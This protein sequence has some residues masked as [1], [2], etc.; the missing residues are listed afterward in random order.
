[1]I[2]TEVQLA[3][4][5][6]LT[7]VNGPV[8]R[9]RGSERVGMYEVVLVGPEHLV[10]EVIALDHREITIQVY[11]ETS[12][13]RS[14]T[15]VYGTGAPLSVELGPG[16][17]SSVFD[18][19]QRPLTA[20]EMRTGAWIGRGI[21]LT[22]LYRRARWDF[23]PVAVEGTPVSGGS[24][25]GL[26]AETS[27]V[28][29]K[30]MVPPGISGR[31]VWLAGE[32]PMTLDDEV[33]RI[34]DGRQEHRVTMLQH[35]P[36][37][38]PRPYVTRLRPSELLTTGQRVLDTFFPIPKGGTSAIPGGF[39]AGKTMLQHQI[40]KW[41]DASVIVYVGC[42]ERGNEMA[43]VLR[44]FPEL[45]DPR[46]GHPLM[47]RT[48][49][50]VNTSNMPV[51]AREASLYTGLTIAEYYRDMGHDVA[52]MADSTSRWAEALREISGRLEELPAEEGF[53]AY[54][55]TRLAEFYERAGRVTTSA[56]DT[57]SVSL[58][59]AVSPPGAD[60]TEPVTQQTRRFVRCFWALDK[61]LAAERHFPAVDWLES[62][63]QYVDDLVPWWE[64]Q[65]YPDWEELRARALEVLQR[66][67]HLQQIVQLI[68]ADALPDDQRLMLETARY[69]REGFLQQ[70]AIDS[71]DTFASIA[72]QIEMLR[73]ILAFHSRAERLVTRGCPLGVVRDLPVINRVLRVRYTIPNDRLD[74]LHRISDELQRQ[75]DELERRYP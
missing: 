8:V 42:G 35:W 1:M 13:L 21:R 58:I 59:G 15:P 41:S 57:G 66:E 18:G 68:G 69:L 19:L 11:E 60:F 34:D 47:E 23:C 40:A 56:G 70:D 30:I 5:G 25:L 39:G 43:D 48:I 26:V 67:G 54:L 55:S 61:G 36:V 12:G 2:G 73:L 33:A 22:P 32:G 62:Y 7:W 29:H 16:L 14:G 71:F 52:M 24:I 9:A 45:R 50:V 63:S 20:M 64:A 53:P 65:G 6:E 38:R 51:A 17:M 74:G 27:L 44:Q 4:V 37:R 72:K 46:S 28:T 31:L 49:L 75:M 10:G 3:A